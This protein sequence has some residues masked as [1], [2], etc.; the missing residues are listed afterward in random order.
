MYGIISISRHSSCDWSFW[1]DSFK[2]FYSLGI[3]DRIFWISFSR[4][5]CI[6]ETIFSRK[7]NDFPW[8]TILCFEFPVKIYG[9]LISDTIPWPRWLFSWN[10]FWTSFSRIWEICQNLWT[11]NFPYDT[12]TQMIIFNIS[13]PQIDFTSETLFSWKDNDFPWETNWVLCSQ[14]IFLPWWRRRNHFNI[15]CKFWIH[16]SITTTLFL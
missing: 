3:V 1:V 4:I 13:F 14:Y 16:F 8:E 2:K 10:F 5:D 15:V 6:Y 12:L 9:L 11:L 7:D